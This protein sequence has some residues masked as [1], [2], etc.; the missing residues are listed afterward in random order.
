M[1]PENILDT[2]AVQTVAQK[3]KL[4]MAVK[5]K[6][7]AYGQDSFL[8]LYT[9]SGT[10]KPML[11]WNSNKEVIR[12]VRNFLERRGVYRFEDKNIPDQTTTQ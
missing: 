12:D 1:K 7:H 10:S 9:W 5:Q 2:K 11:H 4:T 6:E 3:H 8:G